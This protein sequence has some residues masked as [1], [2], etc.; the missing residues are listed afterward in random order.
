MVADNRNEPAKIYD[1]EGYYQVEKILGPSGEMI[2]RAAYY[3]TG[4]ELDPVKTS[5]VPTAVLLEQFM[6]TV[7]ADLIQDH[8]ALGHVVEE[9]LKSVSRTQATAQETP[10]SGVRHADTRKEGSASD[11]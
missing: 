8:G 5:F 3:G 1:D 9:I 7:S 10:Q 11:E 4:G 6:L 2:V